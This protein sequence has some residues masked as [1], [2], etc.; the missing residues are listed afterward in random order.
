MAFMFRCILVWLL[1]FVVQHIPDTDG[2]LFKFNWF[3]QEFRDSMLDSFFSVY[4]AAMPG[5]KYGGNVRPDF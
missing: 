5:A 1:F 3:K 4:L 2:Q